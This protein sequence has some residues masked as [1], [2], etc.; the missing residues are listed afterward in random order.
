MVA[1]HRTAIDFHSVDSLV[2]T[3]DESA[4]REEPVQLDFSAIRSVSRAA[5]PIL[6]NAL[7]RGAVGRA[8]LRVQGLQDTAFLVE[9][10]VAFA[11][12]NREGE[13]TVDG[14]TLE[15]TAWRRSWLPGNLGLRTPARTQVGDE[16]RQLP[17]EM[18]DPH[19]EAAAEPSL[20]GRH[21]ATFI[22]PHLAASFDYK[23]GVPEAVRPWLL[24]VLP[25]YSRSSH[26]ERDWRLVDEV[27]TLIY[28]LI[29]NVREHTAGEGRVRSLLQI[30]ITRGSDQNRLYISVQDTGPGLVETLRA[31][32]SEEIRSLSRR[33]LL[34][35]LLQ[36][37]LPRWRPARGFGLER[38]LSVIGMRRG[39]LYVASHE[40]RAEVRGEG[41]RV[42]EGEPRRPYEATYE[43][44]DGAPRIPGTVITS[45]LPLS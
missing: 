45:M 5:V 40:L 31:K 23:A 18:H 17:L 15:L 28:E 44:T 25:G 11:L 43:V 4:A 9:S 34:D 6:S 20:F 8:P 26:D 16:N 12:A 41:A 27:R 3:W 24:K 35:R 29:E 32:V 42:R 37:D 30:A 7:L 2:R 36:C 21:H 33:V 38:V 1:N 39:T 14:T 19:S 10:G 13:V 22:N